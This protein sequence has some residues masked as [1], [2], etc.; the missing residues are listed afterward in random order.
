MRPTCRVP[1]VGVEGGG[2]SNRAGHGVHGRLGKA[3]PGQA[4]SAGLGRGQAEPPHQ[5]RRA[6]HPQ[7]GRAADRSLRGEDG[8]NR[9]RGLRP[10]P[11][12]RG[13]EGG[14]AGQRDDAGGGGQA[15]GLQDGGGGQG[16]RQ[17]NAV[18]QPLLLSGISDSMSTLGEIRY[19]DL[20]V[21][22]SITSMDFH[23]HWCTDLRKR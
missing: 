19:T 8:A 6:L 18:T 20:L 14:A 16:E 1:R 22:A 7:Q 23:T 4:G 3:G 2:G 10:C 5:L 21:T 9:P 15:R 12:L 17:H 11:H 13:G